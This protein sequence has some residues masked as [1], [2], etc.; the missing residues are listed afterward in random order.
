VSEQSNRSSSARKSSGQASILIVDDQE[1]DRR[2]L[3]LHLSSLEFDQDVQIEMAASIEEGLSLLARTRAAVLFL[4]KNLGHDESDVNQN[5]IE[6]IPRFLALQ[7]HLKIVMVTGSDGHQDA[8]RSMQLGAFDF[9]SKKEP[10]EIIEAKVRKALQYAA[11]DFNLEWMTKLYEEENENSEM[12]GKSLAW[13]RAKERAKL[14]ALNDHAVLFLG[15]TGAGKTTLAKY[16]HVCRKE[17]IPGVKNFVHLNMATLPPSMVERQLFGAEAGAYTDARKDADGLL[18]RAHEGTLFLDEIGETPLEIQSKL[19]TAID[20]G[21]YQRLGGNVTLTSRFKLVCATNQD[22]EEMVIAKTFRADLYNRLA[23]LVMEIPPID[24]RKEDIPDIVRAMLPKVAKKSGKQVMMEEL[25]EDLIQYL[26][27]MPHPGGIRTLEQQLS[28]LFTLSLKDKHGRLILSNWR[29]ALIQK[30][31]KKS[32]P[33]KSNAF[34]LKELAE[35][36]T[37]LI[38]SDFQGIKPT[39]EIFTRRIYQEAR[40]KY[41]NSLET[42]ASVLRVSRATANRGLRQMKADDKI[43]KKGHPSSEEA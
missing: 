13:L 7:P 3:R 42:I 18:H 30:S 33:K 27:E 34:G 26:V 10:D 29:D 20:D 2:A 43:L 32:H 31:K 36:P 41:G 5:G 8:T 17:N 22:L 15:P 40:E 39:I 11:R 9:I 21:T 16:I 38:T 4:D 25:P 19:L 12:G 14:F 6:S 1:S 35:M 23:T 37:D 24:E 28:I